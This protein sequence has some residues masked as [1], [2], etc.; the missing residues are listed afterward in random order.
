M[1]LRFG[2]SG[3]GVAPAG[4]ER[5]E[6]GHHH[7]VIGVAPEDFDFSEPVPSDAQHLHFGAGQTETTLDLPQGEHTLWLLLGDAFHVPH[8]P[9]VMSEPITITV[10]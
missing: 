2:L 4:V 3:M 9:P 10:D 5:E 1:T 8:D 7:L 6:T